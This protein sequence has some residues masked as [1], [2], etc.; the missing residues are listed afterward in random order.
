MVRVTV[1]RVTV[2][3]VT[4]GSGRIFSRAVVGEKAVGTP[5]KH[6]LCPLACCCSRGVTRAPALTPTPSRCGNE[7]SLLDREGGPGEV[8]GETPE[9]LLK[10]NTLVL[11]ECHDG[12][13]GKRNRKIPRE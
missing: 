5:G 1:G 11:V 7:K 10:Q 12:N 4:V 3:R 8:G 13:S 6:D 2:G 9:E